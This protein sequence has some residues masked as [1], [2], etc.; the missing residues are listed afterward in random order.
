MAGYIRQSVADIIANAV[1][2]AAPV[3]AEL[4]A[5]RDAFAASTGHKHDGTSAEGAFVPILADLDGNN[6]VVVDTANN[7]ISVFV[8]VGGS[9]VEQLRIQDGVIVPVTDDDIDL[10]TSSLEFK[11][12]YIDGIA[13]I[14]TLT[15]D[16][17][18]TVAG[19]L[20][21]TG[22]TTL[23][24]ITSNVT[25][26]TD[27]TYDLGTVTNEWRNLYVDGTANIDSLA[28]DTAAVSGNATVGGTMGI[29][30]TTSVS[31]INASGN[32]GVTGTATL[33]TVDINAGAI[34]GTTIGAS[35]AA[36]GTF[37]AVTAS[38]TATLATVDINAGAIDGTIIG[39]S[40]AAA[41]SFTTVTTSGQAT[42]ATADINGGTID[43]AVIG[44]ATP[45]AVT[46][47]TITANTGFVGPLTG[48]VTGNVTGNLTG[49]VV[50][51]V[52]GDLTGNVTAA[53]GTSTF[54]DVTINGGLNMNAGTAATITNLTTPVS[55]ND[56]ATKGYV[57]T[58]ISNLV[59]SAPAALD[60]LNELAA[61]LGDDANF[62]TT[63]TNSIATKLPLAGGTM[64]GAIAMATNKI[65]GL[66]D[67]TAN[68]DAATKFYV[69]TQDTTKLSLSGG[70]MTGAI[71]MGANKITTT[72]TPTDNADLTTKTYVDSIL[73]SA[74]AAATSAAA[75][76]TSASN[77]ATS[78]T[79]AGNSASAAAASFDS[80]DDR[81]LGA[82]AS[83]P[84][85]D[86]DGDP[87]ITGA[88][89]FD[90]TANLMKVYDGSA[91]VDAGSAVNG[92]S[93][94]NVYTATGGQTSFS[95]TYDVGFVDV[96]LN[97]VKLIAG[98]DFTATDGLSVVLATGATAGDTV[99]IVAY[100][101]FNIANTYTQAQADARYLRVTNNLSDLDNAATAR[102]NLGLVIGTDVQAY[103]AT[104]L[105]A[106]DIGVTVQGFDA[107]LLNDAD[108]GVTIQAYDADT[109]KLD[110][111][112][113]FTAN[114]TVTAEFKANSYNETYA[115][116]T[117][118]SN[119]TTVNCETGN[120]FSHTLT[121]N[122]TFTFSNPPASGTAYTM[123]IEIIQDAGASGYTVTWPASVDFPAATAP[124]L[125]A[126]AS[127]VDVFVFT[128]RDGGTT[129]YGFTAGLGLAT[130][131]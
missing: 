12:L 3:N 56:A 26:T 89:Y 27:D 124:T 15:V 31:N 19:T 51:N 1:I 82:K 42:L 39:A 116:V 18:A 14:D 60:T 17:N 44:G 126:T 71:D 6:K 88:L 100:G 2:K 101:A 83:A 84:A 69:D 120:T 25:P 117:S 35:S 121:E 20:G 108:I 77:A 68:Q 23:N 73:G 16:E 118:T 130:P 46:G 50:G 47:T 9:P 78:E 72:Y 10:G 93:E 70:T 38:G 52:T 34:D 127:A 41:G 75:A 102:T 94:R 49:N 55:A 122:T 98:T 112:Q 30:G 4:N 87:L 76:A 74:T 86:N 97:G 105:N 92:T 58:S 85:T 66:G 114:Q 33:A 65:T 81:Y 99:D 48:A 106:A 128:T 129:W 113:T 11:N 40:S 37:T 54:N 62:S 7:R 111:I 21:V 125:T 104:L 107:T 32:L 45:A 115:A 61:A 13:K 64:S 91:W 80:F 22:A 59:D 123:T 119:A 90:T 67:P 8:E 29:T 36:A 5:L 109:A 95:S 24:T 79:N 110:V 103:D 43:G 131:A 28:A 96:Y 63:I 57:D 53:S